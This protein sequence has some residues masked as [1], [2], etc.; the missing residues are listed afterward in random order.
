M[1][2]LGWGPQW[3]FTAEVGGFLLRWLQRNNSLLNCESYTYQWYKDKYVERRNCA[4][5]VKQQL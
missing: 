3:F 4:G 1:D 2:Q 5:L